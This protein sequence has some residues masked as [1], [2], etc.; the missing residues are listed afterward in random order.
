[1][2]PAL[3]NRGAIISGQ[4]GGVNRRDERKRKILD[5]N[6]VDRGF[7]IWLLVTGYWFFVL[8]FCYQL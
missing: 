5:R 7:L 3:V 1:M 2:E 8:R 4:L 6:D